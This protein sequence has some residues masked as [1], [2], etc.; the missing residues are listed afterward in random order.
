MIV[1]ASHIL[2]YHHISLII[3]FRDLRNGIRATRG[4]V[5]HRIRLDRYDEQDF[6]ELVA[7]MKRD[8]LWVA[9]GGEWQLKVKAEARRGHA[10]TRV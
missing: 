8:G 5:R 4:P 9:Q 7:N 2:Q 6:D 10:S 1:L 3:S